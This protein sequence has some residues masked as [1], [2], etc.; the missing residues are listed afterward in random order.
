VRVLV[1]GT[2]YGSSYLRALYA[3]EQGLQ[4]AGILARSEQS[5]AIARQSGVPFYTN[6]DDVPPGAIDAACVAIPGDA[7]FAIVSA[8]LARGIHVLAEHPVY[9]EEVEAHRKTARANRAVYH[10]NA[11]Y[12][13]LD[14]AAVFVSAFRAARARS[15]LLFVNVLTNPRAVYSAIE[16]ITRAMGPLATITAGDGG[17]FFTIAHAGAVTVQT[18]RET[19]EVDDGSSIWVSHNITA[20]FDDGVLAL[21]EAHGPVTWMPAPPPVAQLSAGAEAWARPLWRLLASAPP[22]FGDYAG[23][24]RERANR[25]AL[26]RFAAEMRTG[27]TPPEQSDEH[28]LAVSRAWKDI[29]MAL[30]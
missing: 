5:R 26:A 9:A 2:N 10:V 20:G 27:V 1:C 13:D 8:L 30:T 17:A 4:P 16:L 21:A 14:A 12:S 23:W 15:R 25:I 29:T 22:T 19:S 24:A 3:N 28:L 18:Q 6:V 11:H 7:G